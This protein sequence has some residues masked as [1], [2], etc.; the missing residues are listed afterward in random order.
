M[1]KDPKFRADVAEQIGLGF[2]LPQAE[3]VAIVPNVPN[4][5]GAEV[6]VNI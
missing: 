6:T 1:E 3:P 2:E 5:Q 4:S